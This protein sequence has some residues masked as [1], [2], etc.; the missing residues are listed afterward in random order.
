VLSKHR[1]IVYRARRKILEGDNQKETIINNVNVEISNIVG[2][3]ALDKGDIPDYQKIVTEFS[4]IIP[5]DTAS[6]EQLV[7]QLEQMKT[8]IEITDMLT[9]ITKDMY[10]VREKQVTPDV[11]RQ[12]ERWV[13]LGVYDNL[14]MDHLDAI[15]DLREGIGL[16]GYGQ[17]DPLVEYKNEAFI[18]FESLMAAINSEIVHRIFKVQISTNPPPQSLNSTQK[19]PANQSIVP[20]ETKLTKEAKRARTNETDTVSNQPSANN[21]RKQLGRNDPCWCGSGKKWKKCHYPKLS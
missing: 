10:E 7:R 19:L 18:M 6:Q 11:M 3:Y 15:D 13:C 5:F 4:S 16:R 9:N 21:P 1:E 17:R 2:M 14:W 8:A 12:V 20:T